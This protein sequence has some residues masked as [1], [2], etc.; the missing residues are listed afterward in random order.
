VKTLREARAFGVERGTA[1][2]DVVVAGAAGGELELSK[3]RTSERESAAGLFSICSRVW[4]EEDI[5]ILRYHVM[6]LDYAP[7]PIHSWILTKC[8]GAGML[9]R[10][11]IS[12]PSFRT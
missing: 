4:A 8:R 12:E 11:V 6:A 10:D 3:R 9:A 2:V 7:G 5:K 1:A